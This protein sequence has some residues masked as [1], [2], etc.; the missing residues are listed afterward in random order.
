MA[1]LPA[2]AMLGCCGLIL[3][4]E[5][6]KLRF[7]RCGDLNMLGPGSGTVRRCGLV[8]GGVALLEEVCSYGCWVLR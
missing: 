2:T 5:R 8:G 7:G 6:T 3:L 1:G 4:V